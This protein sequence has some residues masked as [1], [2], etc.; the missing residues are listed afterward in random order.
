VDLEN[1]YKREKEKERKEP[2]YRKRFDAG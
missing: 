2:L 1:F